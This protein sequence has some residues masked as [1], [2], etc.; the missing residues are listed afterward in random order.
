MNPTPV[1]RQNSRK[2]AIY[3]RISNDREGNELGVKRQEEDCRKL[4]AQLN[5]EVLH[6]YIDNDIGASAQTKKSKVRTQYVEMLEKA[7]AGVF[8]YILAYSNSRITRRL[9]ELEELIQLHEE[10]ERKFGKGHG[11]VIHTVVSGDDDLST[12]EGQMLARIKASIDAAEAARISE[13]IQRANLQKAMKGRPALQRRRPFGFEKDAVTHRPVEVQAIQAAV[14]DIINGASITM[15]IR[16]WEKAGIKTSDGNAKWGWQPM[17]RV[18]LSWRTAGVREYKGEPLYNENNELVKAEWEPI[19]TIEEREAAIAKLE[20]RTRRG[21][22]EG[23]WLLQGILQCGLC[24]RNL[25]GALGVKETGNAYTCTGE[26]SHLGI[27]ALLIEEY[28]EKVVFRYLIDKATYGVP[29]V[30][31]TPT[32]EW[33]GETRLQEIS[34]KVDELMVAYNESLLDSRIVFPEVQKLNRERDTLEKAR[35]EFNAEQRPQANSVQNFEDAVAWVTA[36][37]ERTF[38]ERRQA[39]LNEIDFVII[40]KGKSGHGG[41]ALHSHKQAATEARTTIVWKEPH[42]EYN[43]VRA[44]DAIHTVFKIPTDSASER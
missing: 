12:A 39:L 36:T 38:E 6:V 27:N 8:Q 20:E 9:L 1:V 18:L 33:D 40:G 11:T 19:I 37:H 43:G 44:E 15:I 34:A 4:A 23:K 30:E 22:R 10:T 13:R 41:N 24:G 7:R 28:L 2:A 42:F 14:K 29:T 32:V 16:K 21:Q 26:K 5:L 25:Y 31:E 3:C 35:G 17:W